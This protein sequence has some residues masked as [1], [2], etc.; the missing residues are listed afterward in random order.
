MKLRVESLR[1]RLML[2]LLSGLLLAWLMASALAYQQTQRTVSE[3]FDTQQ[4]VLARQLL[5]SGLSA[6]TD[7]QQP[8]P[9]AE[10]LLP[11]A[12]RKQIDADALAFAIFDGAGNMRWN[13]GAYGHMLRYAS[14]VTGFVTQSGY[15]KH[16]RGWRVLFLHDPGRRFTVAV[17]QE[18]A[19]RRAAVR[20]IVLAHLWPWAVMLALLVL[21]TG[22]LIGVQTRPLSTLARE[23][24]ARRPG[25]DMPIAPDRVVSEVRPLIG[26]LNALFE[27]TRNLLAHTRRF[28]ADAAHELRSP[29]TALR[30]QAEVAQLSD[31]DPVTRR[32]ALDQLIVGIDRASRL[33]EQLLALSRLDPLTALPATEPVDWHAL[34]RAAIGEIQD[35]A[36]QRQVT[37]TLEDAP[38][39]GHP[40][41]PSA[42]P[43]QGNPLLLALLL[44]N[45]L[46]NAVRYA[47]TGAHVGLRLDAQGLTVE[48]DG[49]GVA[50]DQLAHIG[51]RFFRPP[52]QSESGSG[53]GLSIVRRI[54]ALHALEL[55]LGNRPEGGFR[56][57]IHVARAQS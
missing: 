28:T 51:E 10:R 29:L 1:G 41:M 15:G 9:P 49:P 37:L 27:R 17:G 11:P 50:P 32:H 26:A 16:D 25:D 20:S 7:A 22:L 52:G 44:R 57:A 12:Q 31:D 35:Q 3:L 8:L 45:L 13:D 23:L 43:A 4:S 46:N 42:L 30:V 55:T 53:L 6:L 36:R 19:H 54:A 18:I 39:Q 5:A 56:A 33:V 2:W 14:G 21:L 38:E 48:D 40:R 34:A 24:R 47:G